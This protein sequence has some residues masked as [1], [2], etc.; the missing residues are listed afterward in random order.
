MNVAHNLGPEIDHSTH[1]GPGISFFSDY[2]D[3]R[4]WLKRMN[5]VYALMYPRTLK[6]SVNVKEK[7]FDMPQGATAFV[8]LLDQTL[9]VSTN[10]NI[11]K[12]SGFFLRSE[13]NVISLY[14]KWNL[15]NHIVRHENRSRLISCSLIYPT[16]GFML[17]LSLSF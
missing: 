14:A 9:W 1:N 17:V 13:S 2:Y 15:C 11:E 7:R 5:N 16:V 6:M 4:D 8:D 3:V 10:S 12:A